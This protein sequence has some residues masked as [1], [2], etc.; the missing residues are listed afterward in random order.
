L[1]LSIDLDWTKIPTDKKWLKQIF[2]I[3]N[4]I[5]IPFPALEW[6]GLGELKLRPLYF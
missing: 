1:F 3:M 4:V 6:N 2:Q 5:K